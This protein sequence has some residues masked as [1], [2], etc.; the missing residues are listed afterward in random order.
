MCLYSYVYVYPRHSIDRT[1]EV[2]CSL[3]QRI[4]D[5]VCQERLG[6]PF[7]PAPVT[8]C[9]Y[10]RVLI[11]GSMSCVSFEHFSTLIRT[12]KNH[13]HPNVH[14]IF[15]CVSNQSTLRCFSMDFL[16]PP[17][18][19]LWFHICRQ[20]RLFMLILNSEI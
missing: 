9:S 19:D 3:L 4:Y 2:S 8:L 20:T 17:P 12:K 7:S 10:S 14:A 13:F 15:E 16:S 6:M 5:S 11:L 18:V 1:F